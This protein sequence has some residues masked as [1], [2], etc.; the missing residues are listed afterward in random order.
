MATLPSACWT[1]IYLKVYIFINK[2]QYF[3]VWSVRSFK[4][5]WKKFNLY[6]SWFLNE[7]YNVG[8]KEMSWGN[9]MFCNISFLL[10]V[11]KVGR[12]TFPWHQ[13]RF[14]ERAVCWKKQATTNIVIYFANVTSVFTTFLQITSLL[15]L[16][17]YKNCY[18]Y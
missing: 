10:L 2:I 6:V 15:V 16:I 14:H 3:L 5:K 18:F 13:L 17:H 7:L 8:I 1:K 9:L 12:D 4:I 11:K